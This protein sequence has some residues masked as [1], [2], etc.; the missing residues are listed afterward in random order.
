ME[1]REEAEKTRL[2]LGANCTICDYASVKKEKEDLVFELS[3]ANA[4]AARWK[5]AADRLS[6]GPADWCPR[7]GEP[8]VSCGP[9]N[10][11]AACRLAWALGE[12]P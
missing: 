4:E 3:K 11:C 6:A 9:E 8:G 5:R 7:R 2:L 1:A 10:D 12:E